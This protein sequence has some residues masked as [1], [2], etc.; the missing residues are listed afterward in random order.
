MRALDLDAVYLAFDVA[1]EKL[2]DSLK[3]MGDMGFG[4]VNLTVPLKEVAFRGLEDID[5]SARALGS[6]NTVKFCKGAMR[7]YSTDGYGFLAAMD[8]AFKTSPKNKT[9][10]LLGCGGAGRA[11]ALACAGAGARAIVLADSDRQRAARLKRD[12]N[13]QFEHVEVSNAPS[14]P[15]AMSASARCAD[16][17]VQATPVG[18]RRE[19]PSLL[20]PEAF[21]EG[22]LVYDLVYMFPETALMR[23]ARSRGARTANGLDMLVFQGARSLS[24]WTGIEAPVEVMRRELV[25]AVYGRPTARKSNQGR[26]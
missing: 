8:K 11:V 21:A 26:V 5:P 15:G 3:V 6:I 22:Q 16:I 24:I 14:A 1:P 23:T 2:I 18:M 7:G 20:G 17:V 25:K 19:D 10:F 9:I 13:S 4:G 12:L